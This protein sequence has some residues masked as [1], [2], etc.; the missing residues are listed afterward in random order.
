MRVNAGHTPT[1]IDITI[2]TCAQCGSMFVRPAH[3]VADTCSAQCSK[4]RA[5]YHRRSLK[6][7]S[8]GG[9]TFTLREIAERDHWRCHLCNGAVPDREYKARDRDPTLDHLLPVSL[10]GEHTRANVALAHNRC[11]WERGNEL[12][13]V[14]LRLIA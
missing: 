5:K 9:E 7:T 11:N 1:S 4:R 2:G 12:I 14:Q 8:S 10:G 3:Y 13:E 6:R